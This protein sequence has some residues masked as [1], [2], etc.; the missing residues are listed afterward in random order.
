MGILG[1]IF[2]GEFLN[3]ERML[4]IA[5]IPSQIVLRG[6][7]ANVINSS[8]QRLVIALGAIAEKKN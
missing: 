5:T 4:E 6:M 3:R 1:G 8:I 2:E 7:F